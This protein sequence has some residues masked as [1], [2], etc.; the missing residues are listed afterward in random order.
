MSRAQR[1]GTG[2]Q[3]PAQPPAQ[4]RARSRAWV[5]PLRACVV[6]LVGS[7]L[8]VAAMQLP[9]TTQLGPTIAAAATAT[10]ELVAV[11]TAAVTC[12]GPETEGLSSVP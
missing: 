8:V 5:G 9:G 10:P 11:T 6:V 4:P 2:A 7:G 1:A 3:P 12:P